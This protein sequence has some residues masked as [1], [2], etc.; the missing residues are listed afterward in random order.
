MSS[1]GVDWS[2]DGVWG[3]SAVIPPAADSA[4]NDEHS[5]TRCHY[6][7][8]TSADTA[9]GRRARARNRHAQKQHKNADND[10]RLVALAGLLG[11]HWSHWPTAL[12]TY[13]R[14]G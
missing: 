12:R 7:A 2:Q 5:A 14:M 11:D 10:C 1:S 13:W 4:G 3:G 9:V 8:D 6:S